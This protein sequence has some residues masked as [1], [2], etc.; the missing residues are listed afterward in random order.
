MTSVTPWIITFVT[1]VT[2][3]IVVFLLQRFLTRQRQKEE[4]RDIEKAKDNALIL[5]SLNALG[6]LTVANSIAL[7]DGKTNGELGSALA[8]YEA[9]A[10]EMYDHLITCHSQSSH[11]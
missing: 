8:E 9:I 5:R 2:S 1:T 11:G 7:R 4:A 10:K 6:K 3:G